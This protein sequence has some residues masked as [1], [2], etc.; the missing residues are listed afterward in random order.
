MRTSLLILTY[1]WPAALKRV[2]QSVAWQSRLPDEVIVS[3]DGS[4][5]E[6]HRLVEQQACD[7]PCRL[8]YLWQ[9]DLGFRA[10]RARNRGIAAARGD[11]LIAIDGDML[12]HRHFIADHLDF[13]QPGCFLIGGRLRASVRETARLLDGGVP[14]FR[15]WMDG[16]FDVPREFH[17]YH[18]LRWP[19]LARRKARVGRGAIMSC[20]MSFWYAD[21]VRSNGFDEAMEGYGSEDLELGARLENAGVLRC[22]LKFAGLAV[23]LNH[24][25]RAPID[26]DDLSMPNNRILSDT[27]RSGRMRCERGLDLHV[28][29]FA[30]LPPDM[31]DA[32][33][34]ERCV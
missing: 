17:R 16:E 3:D 18:A 30:T 12:L 29:E 6:T 20:N 2:L 28:H 22:R 26:P 9:E 25:S 31:R 15:P 32:A 7:F 27:R 34:A 33:C 5:D 19:W 24:A 1:N 10:A 11:Y 8:V 23:H 14:V 13:A 4:R 21:L